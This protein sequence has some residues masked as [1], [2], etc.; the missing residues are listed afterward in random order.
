[1]GLVVSRWINQII[2]VLESLL[3]FTAG[4]F[5]PSAPP[6]RLLDEAYY[7]QEI[8]VRLRWGSCG[9]IGGASMVLALAAGWIPARRAA[10]LRPLEVLRRH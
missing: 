3:A 1:M 9:I 2:A 6:P 8:P 7:L 4:I 5:D 10:R